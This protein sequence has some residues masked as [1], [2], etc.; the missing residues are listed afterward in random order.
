VRT[1]TTIKIVIA[2]V[3]AVLFAGFILRAAMKLA[4][5]A[6]H[7]LAGLVVILLLVGWLLL[8]RR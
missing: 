5:T 1:E 3:I 7:S 4:A 2:A 8:K 6:M